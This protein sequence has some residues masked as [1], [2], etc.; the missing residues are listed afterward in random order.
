[1]K[2]EHLKIRI[3]LNVLKFVH[4]GD[5]NAKIDALKDLV[6]LSKYYHCRLTKVPKII[7][8]VALIEFVEAGKSIDVCINRLYS[9]L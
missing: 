6:Q 8:M 7:T 1:M 5:E 2:I 3:I 4:S 9:S